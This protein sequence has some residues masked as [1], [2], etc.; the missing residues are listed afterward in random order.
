LVKAANESADAVIKELTMILDELRAAMFLTSSPSI[1]KL[2]KQK[3]IV[4]GRTRDWIEQ[5]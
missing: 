1:S 5:V 4:T 2:K 3:V